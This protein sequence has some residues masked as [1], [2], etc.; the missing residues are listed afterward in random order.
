MALL[1]GPKLV[2]EEFI[3][4]KS[5]ILSSG[6]DNWLLGCLLLFGS[7][8]F[9]SFWMILQVLAPQILIV[10]IVTFD[11]FMFTFQ[12]FNRFQFLQAYQTTHIHLLGCVSWHH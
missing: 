7:S 4:P 9:W 10:F 5:L 3:P 2:N 8:W 6:A 1:K 11:R 12:S